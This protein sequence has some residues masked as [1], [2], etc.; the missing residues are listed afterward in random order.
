MI[1]T[2][3]ILFIMSGAFTELED[4]IKKR[5]QKHAIGFEG[6]ISSKKTS[7][8]YLKHVKAE[9][10]ISYGFES[11]FIGR[12]PVIACLDELTVNDLYNILLNPNNS[13]VVGKK[14]D[15]LAQEIFREINTIGSKS[16]YAEISHI[17][18]DVKNHIDKIREQCRNIV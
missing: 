5:L 7:G 13:V 11:E 4:I 17:V 9:D 10:L 16:N 1:N 3:D 12:L 2:K 6:D 18:V 15:F 8:R 14:L